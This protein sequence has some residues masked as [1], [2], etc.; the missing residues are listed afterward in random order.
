MHS[1][2]FL[3][4]LKFPQIFFYILPKIFYEFSPNEFF[5][6]NF[7]KIFFQN[8][9]NF[10][11]S[12][13]LNG[14]LSLVFVLSGI[15]LNALCVLVFLRFRN[16]GGTTPIIHYYLVARGAWFSRIFIRG[17]EFRENFPTDTVFRHFPRRA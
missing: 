16:T 12:W 7:H 15:A 11:L 6:K 9:S 4:L 13:L 14:P 5:L 17:P 2:I 10:Q 3:R 1:S 8:F